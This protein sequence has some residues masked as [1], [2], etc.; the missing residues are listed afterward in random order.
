MEE[1]ADKDIRFTNA[2]NPILTN[3]DFIEEYENVY[4]EPFLCTIHRKHYHYNSFVKDNFTAEHID[5]TETPNSK[6]TI[7]AYIAATD[8]SH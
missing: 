3:K 6:L 8:Q 4:G 5:I 7:T 1:F 2:I